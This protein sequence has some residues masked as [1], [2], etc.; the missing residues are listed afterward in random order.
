MTIEGLSSKCGN[1]SHKLA[2][3]HSGDCVEQAISQLSSNHLTDLYK[4]G[5]NNEQIAA[6]GFI[7]FSDAK[8][9]NQILNWKGSSN[10]LGPCLVFPY[11]HPDGSRIDLYSFC[12]IKPDKPRSTNGKPHKYESPVGRSCRIYFP[13]GTSENLSN[14]DVPLIITE[15]EKKCAAADQHGFMCVGLGGVWS[16]CKKRPDQAAERELISDFDHIPLRGREVFVVYDSDIVTNSKVQHAEWELA[17][18]LEKRGAKVRC[19]RL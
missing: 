11:F 6:C 13:P 2:K 5:L 7:T 1:P 17:K 15:G 12:R 14:I 10:G 19:I 18:A 9:I 8:Q 16:W 4:S 3:N